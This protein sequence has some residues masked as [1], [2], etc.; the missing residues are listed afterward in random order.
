MHG[1]RGCALGAVLLLAAC[2]GD[3]TPPLLERPTAP[4]AGAP[5]S[6]TPDGGGGGVGTNW[7]RTLRGLGGN[8]GV[9]VALATSGDVVVASNHDRL[10]DLGEG[11]QPATGNA[12]VSR[13]SPEGRHRWTHAEVLTRNCG[14]GVSCTSA[15]I[16]AT[17]A[18]AGPQDLSALA[19][20]DRVSGTFGAFNYRH[21]L[22]LTVLDVAGR[23]R[24]KRDIQGPGGSALVDDVGFDA[25]G[26]LLAAGYVEG[27]GWD[28]G[29][30]QGRGH[31]TLLTASFVASY[32]TA[33]ALQW[34]EVFG[35]ERGTSRHA[36]MAVE[37]DGSFALTG[38]LYGRLSFGGPE[39]VGNREGQLPE[40]GA[41][42][43]PRPFIARF[44]PGGTHRW[45]RT[46]ACEDFE[47]KDLAIGPAGV[48]LAANL[49]EPLT[50][51][52][53]TV[54][55]QEGPAGALDSVLV[56][57]TPDGTE[58][59][60]RAVGSPAP[61]EML[62]ADWTPEGEVWAALSVSGDTEIGGAQVRA[63]LEHPGL[64]LARVQGSDGTVMGASS[65]RE[66]MRFGDLD[67]DGR[68]ALAVTG[69]L[70][71]GETCEE[72]CNGATEMFLLHRVP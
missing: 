62:G 50:F 8:A 38:V 29:D 46:L 19:T 3:R 45:S 39:L 58:R 61:D 59:W 52:G 67:V 56:T 42:V 13:F 40:P 7:E 34:V 21:T 65:P 16:E 55:P 63:T 25:A 47:A 9:S 44:G 10:P 64:V 71:G 31:P 33:G 32:S 14:T 1:W 20:V 35:D 57:F 69:A 15:S 11:Q 36:V 6:G 27:P 66:A 22:H 2:G 4:D 54:A 68:G 43:R 12:V 49:Y 48:L 51:A 60:A 41:R 37:P 18:A 5:D 23:V 30:G 72:G 70:P 24:W 26:N 17:A 53:R 28:F